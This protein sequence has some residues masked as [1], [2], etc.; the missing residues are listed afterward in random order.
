MSNEPSNNQD[1]K[2]FNISLEQGDKGFLLSFPSPPSGSVKPRD[3]YNF[4]FDS[5]ITG[6]LPQNPRTDIVFTPSKTNK[7]EEASILSSSIN[8]NISIG[9]AIK[10]KHKAET[11][12]LIR[13]QIKD[14]YNNVL[15]TDYI[16]VV[17]SPIKTVNINASLVRIDTIS[18]LGPNGGRLLRVDTV[19]ASASLVSS[20][21]TRMVVTG[22]GIPTDATIFIGSFINSNRTE[23]ELLPYFDASST[24]N[25]SNDFSH[26]GSYSFTNVFSCPSQEDLEQITFTRPYIILHKSNNWSYF[27][28][29]KL[30]IQFIP[31]KTLV[32]DWENIAILVNIK[33]FEALI[34]QDQPSNIPMVSFI[35]AGGRVTNDSLCINSI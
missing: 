22:P 3:I 28:R 33:N 18:S 8:S 1:I 6:R 21:F 15:Y 13:L 5:P 27:F 7:P 23:I 16:L 11:S 24:G 12:T 14:I 29:R 4:H 9:L 31:N 25:V 32:N 35:E 10:A 17:C 2:R 34:P 20:L 26:R 19:D 30:V